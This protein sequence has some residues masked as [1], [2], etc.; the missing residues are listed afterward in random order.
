MK[1]IDFNKYTDYKELFNLMNRD[2]IGTFLGA[3]CWAQTHNGFNYFFNEV[4]CN[5][6]LLDYALEL[7]MKVGRRKKTNEI[8]DKLLGLMVDREKEDSKKYLY[9]IAKAVLMNESM[10]EIYKVIMNYKYTIGN[11]CKKL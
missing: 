1:K 10:L 8:K 2:Q 11:N 4:D 5:S 9:D 7:D 3:I 6:Y